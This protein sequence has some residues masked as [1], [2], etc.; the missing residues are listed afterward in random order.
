MA[1]RELIFDTHSHYDDEAF[2]SDRETV[3]QALNEKG[4]GWLVDVGADIVTS[5]QALGLAKKYGFVYAALGVH[6]SETAAVEEKD[7]DWLRE[8]CRDE[9]VVAV[10]EIGLDYHW[11]EPDRECQR[12]W[13]LRQIELAKEVSLPIIVHS[14]DA[15]EETMEII[16]RAKAYECGGVIHCYSYSPEMAK[17]YVDMGFYIGV[18][19]VITFKNAKKLKRTVEEIPPDRIVLET[20]CPYMAPEPNRG[21]R[22]DSSQLIYVA[23]KIGELKGMDPAEVIRITTENARTLYRLRE[24]AL[25]DRDK[26]E[27]GKIG[28]IGKSAGNDTPAAKT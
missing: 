21:K 1:D 24:R 23:E 15:A 3:L 22:N 9:K 19:G 12:K 2:D 13:F 6:P 16:R 11:E 20:D 17:Q 27:E 4:V 18:G 5:R 14:R 7:M 10:G 28:E 8:N 26:K 25:T